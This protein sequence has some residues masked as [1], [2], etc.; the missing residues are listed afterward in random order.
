MH[1]YIMFR[2]AIVRGGTSKGVFF[3][4]NDL[5]E[6]KKTREKVILAAFGS[7]DIR[8]IDGLGGASSQ[9]SKVMII[10]PS[11]R[12]DADVEST[13]GQVSIATP[14]I[15][16]GGNCGNLTA[17]IGPF[18]IEQGMVKA[19]EPSTVVRIYNTNTKKLII[20]TVPVKNGRPLQHGDYAIPGVP[21]TG[22]RI[23]MEFV[24]P[25]G[26]F[27]GKLL[28]TGNTKDVIILDDK[29][30]FT[31]S[32]VDAANPVIF[33]NAEELNLKGTEL[34][35]ELE[36]RKDVMDTLEKIRSVIAEMMGM[37][38]DRN[39]A[40]KQSPGL[41]KIGVVSAP[42]EYTTTGGD[43][44]NKEAIDVL[45]RLLSMQTAHRSY[46]ATGA[47]CTAS[48]AMVKGTLVNEYLPRERKK[49]SDIIKIA[50]PYGLMDIG[51]KWE[52]K[53]GRTLIISATVG[54]TARR[55][56]EGWVYI[57]KDRIGT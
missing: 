13:F 51:V 2:C 27:S 4:D 31:V 57:P 9:A 18:A 21:G 41:P 10:S 43:K 36:A 17:G 54:R 38:K 5:P 55:I 45:G 37:V 53:D 28:P 20:A 56:M 19:E 14:L 49:N 33:V 16:W 30:K 3:A 7:P 11:R 39:L 40:T 35:L 12:N 15:D 26:S 47:I 42:K 32:I 52:E 50:H 34:P 23:S 6:D 22:P 44:I 48:A 24:D 8:Q 25:A 46:M 29:R 1:D